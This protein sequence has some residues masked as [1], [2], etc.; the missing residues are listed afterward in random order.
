MVESWSPLFWIV[1]LLALAAWYLYTAWKIDKTLHML[2]LNS[3]R[4]ERYWRWFS[5]NR[6]KVFRARDAVL[7]AIAILSF[8]LN[9]LF[10]YVLFIAV[11]LILFVMRPKEP[12]KK[13]LVYTARVKRLTVTSHLLTVVVVALIAY[14]QF[15]AHSIFGAFAVTIALAI[16]NNVAF[17][18]V[19]A[20]NVINSPVEKSIS[21]YYFNDAE[22]RIR[23]MPNLKVVGITGSYGKTSTKHILNTVLSA[24][25][26]VLMTPESYNTKLGVTRTI[27][28]QLK[29]IH[30]IF[31]AEMGAK[32]KNDIQEICD[33]VHQKYGVLT[34]IGP[35][36]LETFKTLENIQRT[37]FELIESLPADGVG[38]LN[39]D[40]ANIMSYRHSAKARLVYYGI[41][42][43]DLDYR[44]EDVAYHAKGV[45]FKVV[46]RDGSSAVFESRLLGR[47]NIYNI[48][49]AVALG[50]EMG[51]DMA[52]MAAAVKKAMPVKHRLELSQRPGSVT[53]IDD[54]FN[55]NP[56]G[57]KMA[58]EVLGGM[59]GKRILVTPGMVELGD[60]EYELNKAFGG[61]A[62]EACDFII[63]VGEKQTKPIQDGL[64][65]AQ[66][67]PDRMYIAKN[68]NDAVQK[69][70]AVTEQGSFILFENDLPDTYNE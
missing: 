46:K 4:S 62:A 35:Q 34:A 23:E 5:G 33:L 19:I 52:K 64:A 26:N 55:S 49:A 8:F 61:Y 68:F 57:S 10:M 47:F 6:R 60:K 39:K 67:P 63:L 12:E 69:M 45:T 44:A 37:K 22:K 13:K 48:L 41:E 59:P 65:E 24:K 11:Y 2:Q 25:F 36:H 1:N 51:I 15:S 9:F 14:W 28:E 32:Q 17:L 27:R 30:E 3:Y 18:I 20:A 70:N 58:L 53:V 21:R 50:S 7:P 56:S 40:D 38:F 31:I 16:L 29:P 66:Y 42:A 54:S 43:E